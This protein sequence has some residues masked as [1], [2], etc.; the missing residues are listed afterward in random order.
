MNKAKI[1]HEEESV[2]IEKDGKKYVVFFD[3]ED[4]GIS[5]EIEGK[6]NSF[7]TISLPDLP[8]GHAKFEYWREW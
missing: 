1:T 6:V 4:F 2:T 8:S 5:V 3:K 7:V